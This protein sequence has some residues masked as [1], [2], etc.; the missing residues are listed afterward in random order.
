MEGAELK[1]GFYSGSG[2]ENALRSEFRNFLLNENKTKGFGK[3][4]LDAIRKVAKGGPIE[5][6]LRFFGKAAPTGIV[7]GG[8]GYTIGKMSGIPGAEYAIPAMGAGARI[9]ATG[10]TGRNAEQAL[11]VVSG[12]SPPAGGNISP[13]D[14]ARIR[15][16]MI[17][18]AQQGTP[19]LRQ[20]L[21]PPLRMPP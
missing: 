6:V 9:A 15:T 13:A 10:A 16:L 20:Q 18:Q 1:A 21:M 11:G 17:L 4:E 3:E 7:S 14:L 19:E 5:N 2:Y 8:L 12:L